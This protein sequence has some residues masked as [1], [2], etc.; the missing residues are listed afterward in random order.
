MVLGYYPFGLKYKGYNDVV[1]ANANSVAQRFRY[2]GMELEESLGID[3]YEMDMRQYDPAIARWTSIDPVTHHSMS[4]YTA[5]DNN[6]VFWADPSGADSETANVEAWMD[7]SEA[8]FRNLN[9]AFD[10]ANGVANSTSYGNVDSSNQTSV[11]YCDLECQ[12]KN[13]KRRFKAHS[14]AFDMAGLE[15]DSKKYK[16]L[17]RKRA[18]LLAMI[19]DS[20]VQELVA[21]TDPF[22]LVLHFGTLGIASRLSVGFSGIRHIGKTRLFYVGEGAEAFARVWSKNDNS[23]MTI[24]DTWYGKVGDMLTPLMS[25]NNARVMWD[26]LSYIYAR[27]ANSAHTIFGTQINKLGTITTSMTLKS[28][29]AWRRI[30]YRVLFQREIRWTETILKRKSSWFNN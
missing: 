19:S 7:Q 1:S 21:P 8:E 10:A 16:R 2:N 13:S 30:E 12:M 23:V 25:K 26:K 11:S 3:W 9:S 14:I 4:T 27:G 15:K 20:K 29:S 17:Q 24:F 18:R 28:K 22:S 6:P 5:F